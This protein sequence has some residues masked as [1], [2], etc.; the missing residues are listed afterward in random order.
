MATNPAA[1]L[2]AAGHVVPSSAVT[3]LTTA[4]GIAVGLD[5]GSLAVL[6]IALFSGQLLI[7]WSNDLIDRAR[8]RQVGRTEK[9]LVSGD[10]GLTTAR[11]AVAVAAVVCVVA[12]M[13]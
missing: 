6:A 11:A 7:G 5:V 10:L 9:P 8:D 12:S 2:L 3:L 1:T 4:L 13:A